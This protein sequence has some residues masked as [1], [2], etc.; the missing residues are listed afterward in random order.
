MVDKAKVNEKRQ[1]KGKACVEE[2][3]FGK[4]DR[5]NNTAGWYLEVID[6]LHS[7]TRLPILH[8]HHI[9]AAT[10]TTTTA[11]AVVVSL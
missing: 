7:H 2:M 11:V 6:L 1:G 10:T 4:I 8:H 5:R 9:T 3:T